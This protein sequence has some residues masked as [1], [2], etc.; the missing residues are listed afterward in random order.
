MRWSLGPTA[1]LFGD[2]DGEVNFVYVSSVQVRNGRMTDES[3]AAMGAPTAN[4]IPGFIKVT[5]TATGISIE[6]TGSVLEHASSV[7]G[8]WTVISGAKHPQVIPSIANP[9]TQFYRVRQ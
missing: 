5:T 7:T 4:K 9:T 3:I 2:E 1:L 8:P 6:W